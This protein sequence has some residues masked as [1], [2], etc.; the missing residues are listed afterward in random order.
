VELWFTEEQLP[1]L[2]ISVQVKSIVYDTT[3]KFQKLAVYDTV[4]LGRILVLDD[5][6]QS[7]EIDE[8]LYHESLVHVPL[9]SHQNPENILIIGGGDGGSLREALRHP[10]VKEV[11]LVDID[12]GVIDAAKRFMPNW[13]SGY[14]DPRAKVVIADGLKFVEEAEPKYDVVI[15][16]STDP[17]GPGEALF[18]QDFYRSIRKALREGGMM[19]AQTECPLVM[20]ELV[21]DIFQR[22]SNV[23]PVTRLYTAPV[24]TYPGG[25]WSFTCGSLEND[26]EVPVRTPDSSWNLK[27]YSP[28]IHARLF[29]LNPKLKKDVL[30]E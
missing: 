25:W 18:K 2:K 16:D 5:V 22:I 23:F 14:K 27:F 30:G 28:E 3:T 12:D 26:P 6:I 15:V 20:P 19:V 17:V 10:T 7:T 21:R 13:S 9:F 24:P 8:Y 29:V 1:G 4:E 11:T